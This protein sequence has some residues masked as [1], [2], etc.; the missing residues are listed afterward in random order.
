MAAS[1]TFTYPQWEYDLLAGLGAPAS[2]TNLDALNYWGQSEGTASSNNPLAVSGKAAG[3]TKCLAQCGSSSPVYA[4][5][6]EQDGVAA[7]VAFLLHNNYANVV[8]AFVKNSGLA[9]IF[10][11]INSSGWCKGCQ[12][13]KYPEALYAA[14]GSNAPPLTAQPTGAGTAAAQAGGAPGFGCAAKGNVFSEGGLAGIGSFAFTYC[15]AKALVSGLCILGGVGVAIIGLSFVLK[16][17]GA[18]RAAGQL[19]SAVPIPIPV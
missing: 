7:N 1:S 2:T 6:T 8:S 11:A 16:N 9:A 17:S 13:G 15:N 10:S 3:A 14:L 12:G 19:A 5:D 4:Y 18:G